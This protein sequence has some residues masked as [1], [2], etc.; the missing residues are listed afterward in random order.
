MEVFP[1]QED[2]TEEVIKQKVSLGKSLFFKLEMITL[3]KPALNSG[4]G[5]FSLVLLQKPGV[6]HELKQL[7]R[8]VSQIKNLSLHDYPMQMLQTVVDNS[9]NVL[10]IF[11]NNLNNYYEQNINKSD[12][13]QL[14]AEI[15]RLGADYSIKNAISNLS[16]ILKGPIN[17]ENH[18]AS[19]LDHI[20]GLNS[21]LTAILLQRLFNLIDTP[22]FSSELKG[23]SKNLNELKE[24][25][26]KQSSEFREGINRERTAFKESFAKDKEALLNSLDSAVE[27]AK[28]AALQAGVAN[29]YVVFRDEAASHQRKAW[30]WLLTLVASIGFTIYFVVN[31]GSIFNTPFTTVKGL[32][33]ELNVEVI[34]F[35]TVQYIANKVII[36]SAL[37]YALSICA[38]N[39]KA[40]R[41]NYVLNKHRQNA[42]STFQAFTNATTD[43]M[44]KNAVLLEATHTIFSNQHTGYMNPDTEGDSPNKIIEIIKGTSGNK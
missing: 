43:E 30:L 7:F 37:F 12:R 8:L 28:N 26:T 41:H 32:S 19:I 15:P 38:K 40:H 44:T 20:K 6:N 14:I 4:N 23:L 33:S 11:Y 42:L 27:D 9:N 35:Q 39:Y 25:I 13:P 10:A 29:H 17:D 34:K 18:I 22:N 1:Q 31:F 2:E 16:P 3:L 36:I 21:S 5:L 24:G